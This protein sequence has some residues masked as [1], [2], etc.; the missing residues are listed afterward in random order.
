[1]SSTEAAVASEPAEPVVAPAPVAETRDPVA[2]E[3][4]VGVDGSAGSRA[5]LRWA[6][7][8]ADRVGARLHLVHVAPEFLPIA[9]LMPVPLPLTP[10]E[11]IASGRVVLAAAVAE[12]RTLVSP[13]R[14]R[15]TLVQGD[16]ARSLCEAGA[17]ARMIVVGA[18]RDSLIERIVLGAVVG[19]VAAAATVPVAVVPADW[20]PLAPADLVAVGIKLFDEAP[21]PLLRGALEVA[22]ERKAALEVLHVWDLPAGY[23]DAL[24]P[25]LDEDDWVA[26]VEA[27][28]RAGAQD[29]LAAFPE[30]TVT[31]R[32]LWGE[33]T[34]ELQHASARVDLLVIA[35]H[36][37]GFHL[38]QF[39]STGRALLRHSRCPLLVLPTAETSLDEQD[40]R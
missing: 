4:L 34:Q 37:R 32:A 36:G 31:V 11:F 19:A 25:L 30:V 20:S 13:D 9:G 2:G 5:A 33:P 8:E 21:E 38:A 22:A 18:E 12:A 29:L 35:R 40:V 24:L 23:S 7:R 27:T 28:I 3:I 6:V 14:V 1:M 10:D 26:M 39:G 16:R 15:A 17:S